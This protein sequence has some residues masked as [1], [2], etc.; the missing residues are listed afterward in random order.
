M[1]IP[2]NARPVRI[3]EDCEDDYLVLSRF[4]RQMDP[5]IQ[6]ERFADSTSALSALEQYDPL[7]SYVLLDLNLPPGGGMRVLAGMKADERWRCT[8]I[9]VLSGSARGFEVREA[10][11][12]GASSYLVKPLKPSDLADRLAVLHRYWVEVVEHAPLPSEFRRG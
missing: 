3:V 10:Y 9:I 5:L 1:N 12:A 4:Y 11:R 7:P 6:I 8:P 2:N